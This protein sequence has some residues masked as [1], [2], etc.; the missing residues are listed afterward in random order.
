MS[1]LVFLLE[2]RS[3]QA[4]LEGLLPRVFPGLDF[5]CVPHEGKSD[6]ERSI[7]RKLRAWQEPG[8]RFVVVRDSDG[9]DCRA[10]KAR[11]LQLCRQGGREDTLVRIVCQEL[12][13]WYFG[14]TDAMAAAF[15]DGKLRGLA[16]RARYRNPDDIAKPS[17]VIKN[18]VPGFQKIAGA[19][20]MS[21]RLSGD[22]NRSH[23]FAVFLDGV[24]GRYD[25]PAE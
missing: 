20:A 14:D 6:L 22:G 24:A 18:L 5:R 23:S 17:R 1:K 12:E 10:H 8:V 21:G 2:E 3:M 16:N 13:S 4:L 11:L 25:A 15:D 9:G 7:P 19:R